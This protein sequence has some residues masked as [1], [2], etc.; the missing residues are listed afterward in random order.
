MALGDLMASR[1][2]HSSSSP[3]PSP[4]PSRSRSTAAAPAPPL[5]NHHHHH[6]NHNHAGDGLLAANGPEPRN[7][8]EAAAEVEKPAPVAYLPQ[9]VVLCEQ[10]HEPDGIDEAAAAATAPSTSGLVSRWRPKDRVMDAM[11]FADAVSTASVVILG[12]S[13]DLVTPGLGDP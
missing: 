6:Q 7:G 8:L 1:L 4:S 2:V 3:S 10:R 13:L 11:Q 12:N 9:V 5:P